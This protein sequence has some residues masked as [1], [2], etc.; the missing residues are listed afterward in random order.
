MPWTAAPALLQRDTGGAWERMIADEEAV[1]RAAIAVEQINGPILFLSA[2]RDEFW[3]SAEMSE[4]MV[5][6]L[7]AS[8]FR[9]RYEHVAIEGNHGAP[10]R[11]GDLVE[12]FLG[13]NLLADSASGCARPATAVF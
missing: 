2:T 9:Y 13:A 12:E 4:Q 8:H 7:Q 1:R 3:P 11:R 10:Q 6:R 5:R